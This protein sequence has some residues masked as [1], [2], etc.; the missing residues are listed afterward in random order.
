[1]Q[2]DSKNGMKELMRNPAMAAKVEKLIAAGVLKVGW[3]I[4][5]NINVHYIIIILPKLKNDLTL[6][7]KYVIIFLAV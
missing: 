3:N 1:M 6:A 2:S 4:Y 5:S 7:Y